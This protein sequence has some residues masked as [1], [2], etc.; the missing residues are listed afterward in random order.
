M[1]GILS[2]KSSLLTFG[3]FERLRYAQSLMVLLNES[4]DLSRQH[5]RAQAAM[6]HTGPMFWIPCKLHC[7]WVSM[8]TLPI[9]EFPWFVPCI[10]SS[11]TPSSTVLQSGVPVPGLSGASGS[12]RSFTMGMPFNV[13]SVACTTSGGSGDADLFIRWDQNVYFMNVGNSKVNFWDGSYFFQIHASRKQDLTECSLSQCRTENSNSSES[14]DA[15]AL[16]PFTD[17]PVCRCLWVLE[18]F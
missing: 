17:Y 16:A 3:L 5:P 2:F 7:M 4:D 15:N 10:A 8:D 6:N 14:C 9:Q 18:L 11:T 12:T 13:A 1:L